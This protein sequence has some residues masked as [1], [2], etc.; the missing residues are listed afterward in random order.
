MRPVFAACTTSVRSSSKMAMAMGMSRS[1]SGGLRAQARLH[2][3]EMSSDADWSPGAGRRFRL[4]A[5]S[6][7]ECF[8]CQGDPFGLGL[9][10]ILRHPPDPF[11]GVGK[12]LST[13]A[14]VAA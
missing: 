8:L 6:A 11:D 2:R 1:T 10:H 3:P 14:S 4:V 5:K 9:V 7:V 12:L 13:L